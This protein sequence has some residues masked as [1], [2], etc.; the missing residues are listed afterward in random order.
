MKEEVKKWWGKSKRD[1]DNSEFNL[2]NK[3]YEES[4][5]FAQQAVEKA[6]KALDIKKSDNFVKT[7]DLIFLA[8][9]I[10]ASEEIIEKCRKVN[11]VYTESRYPDFIEVETYTK[12]KS[13][14]ILL[15]TK[16]VLKWIKKELNI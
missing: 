1:L 5:F 15:S 7:H 8:K 12:E 9:R 4:C 13:K 3:R 2:K 11:P 14:E 10:E 6:L 16:E